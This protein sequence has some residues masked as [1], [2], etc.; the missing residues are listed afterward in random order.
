MTNLEFNYQAQFNKNDYYS[1][2]NWYSVYFNF[3]NTPIFF[4]SNIFKF[5]G[6]KVK[7]K[8]HL[9]LNSYTN[10][11]LLPV[12]IVRELRPEKDIFNKAL[13]ISTIVASIPNVLSN[14]QLQLRLNSKDNVR[15]FAGT[16][17]DFYNLKDKIEFKYTFI[18]GIALSYA[19][20]IKAYWAKNII[21]FQG[22]SNT[23]YL[24]LSIGFN[25]NFDVAMSV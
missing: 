2:L 8:K 21:E 5:S 20:E 24:G 22:I 10:F 1:D 19:I 4:G 7:K 14:T 3:R 16:T 12:Y 13:L 11:M 9:S 6:F 23:E 15:L 25:L 17:G 18:A